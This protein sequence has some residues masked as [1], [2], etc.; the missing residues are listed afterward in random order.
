MK[1]NDTEYCNLEDLEKDAYPL[2]E[3]SALGYLCS[4]SENEATLRWNRAQFEQYMFIPRVLVDVSS[5]TT[6]CTILGTRYPSPV[7]IA[8]MAMQKLVHPSGGEVDMSK[9]AQQFRAPMILSTMSTSRMEDVVMTGND[10]LYFQL[11]CL[12]D[13]SITERM[14]HDAESM[15]FQGLVVTVDAARL[16]K[17]E[18]DERQTFTLPDSLSLEILK[19]YGITDGSQ[20]SS[21]HSQQLQS[22]FGSTFSSLID[23][24]L[25][26]EII[27][28]LRSITSMPII[29]K[30]I[31]SRAD[32]IKAVHHY[33]VDGIIVSNHGGRQLDYAVPTLTSLREIAPIAKNKVA[34][35]VD[36]GI[37]R[38]TDVVKCLCLGADAV[39]VGRPFLW[40]LC[41]GGDKG[42]CEALTSL[43]QDIERTMALLGCC[44]IRDLYACRRG[45]FRRGLSQ[46]L[47]HQKMGG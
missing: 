28:W 6:E 29:L 4:G 1:I 10:H 26:W 37:R 42:V 36:G 33:K 13:R 3:R 44:T 15:G 14:V 12:K 24:S 17:R 27:P 23:D 8:P 21:H 5:V 9:G 35:W 34:L 11:Y 40:A 47:A 2:I 32:A 31:L 30:G 43:Q 20:S 18:A 16:G 46:Y 38:G 7:I 25:T 22:K 41:L 45:L 39:L 19:K